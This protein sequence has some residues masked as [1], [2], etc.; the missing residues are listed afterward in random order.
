M[1]VLGDIDI[2]NY[3]GPKDFQ[4]FAQY[5]DAHKMMVVVRRLD[6]N[7]GWEESINVLF[8]N[9]EGKSVILVGPSDRSEKAVFHTVEFELICGQAVTLLP[10][11]KPL[12]NPDF[13]IVNRDQFNRLFH[14]DLVTLPSGIFAAGVKHGCVYLYNETFKCHYMIDL[15]IRNIVGVLL[16]RKLFR[17]FYFLICA[18]DG[19]MELHYL[20]KRDKPIKIGLDECKSIE[21]IKMEDPSAY[22]VFHAGKY[23]CGQSCHKFT[24]YTI[25]MPDRYYFFLNRYNQYRSIHGGTP[26]RNKLPLIVYASQPRGGKYNFTSRQD[27]EISQREYFYNEVPKVNIIAPRWIDRSDQ[28][29]YKYVLDID[30]NSSTWDAT[31]WKLNSNS[32]ILKVEGPWSQWFYDDFK[33]WTHYV[34]IKDDMSD[35]QEKYEW[36]ESH[37]EECE[38]MVSNCK[39]LFQKAY[40]FTNV[41][42]YIETQVYKM[43]NLQP[44]IADGTRIFFVTNG[45]A[46]V[47]G[48]EKL[49]KFP[50]DTHAVT[51]VH[52]V[53]TMLNDDDI[54][55]FVKSDLLDAVCFDAGEFVKRFES[56]GAP[57]V[58]SAEKNLWPECVYTI[59]GKLD[60]MV[61]DSAF[62]Y[63]QAGFFAGRAGALRQLYK[64]RVYSP[65]PDFIDQAYYIY[66]YETG[67]YGI[68]LD[69][70]HRLVLNTYLCSLEERDA[71]KLCGIPFINHNGGR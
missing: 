46:N 8:A 55:V 16:S 10:R 52:D 33:P 22:P 56:F 62:K 54:V 4:V 31:A 29:K 70:N 40:R 47:P 68:V 45:D 38:L 28:L 69:S 23:V 63:L 13:Q 36:C 6:G 39:A 26:F 18:H 14:S 34:P 43:A 15:T 41:M 32:V 7:Q 66:A 21:Y 27:I 17:K 61:R 5:V 35:I 57:I 53:A 44:Y 51:L 71:A 19:Y 3:D 30:G 65:T 48:L 64:E 42:D 12:P 2:V 9:S 60:A 49:N 24:D 58:F 67:K 37:Q 50:R 1:S 59:K 11:Y 20:S 25:N